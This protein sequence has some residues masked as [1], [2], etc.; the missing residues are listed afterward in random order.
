MRSI[1]LSL[2]GLA[3]VLGAAGCS[4]PGNSDKKSPPQCSDGQD[5]DGDGTVDFPDDLGCVS[6]S[7]DSEDSPQSPQCND[8]R[9]NDG[10]G[11][12]DYPADPGCFAEQADS[13]VDDCPSGPNC[14]QCADD[15]DNDGNGSIDYP[16]DPGCESASDNQ[17]FPNNPV[18]CGATMMIETLPATGVVDGVL[19]AT[20]TSMLVSPC[21]GGGGSPARAYV[22]HLTQ[23]KVVEIS[24]DDSTTTAD[25]IIDLRSKNC[26]EAAAEIA[27][28]D[29][30]SATNTRSSLLEP[31]A[32]GSYY[33]IVSGIDSATSGPF[34]LQVKL[35]NGEGTQ[36]TTVGDCGP[37]LVCRTPVGM[38]SNVC[39]R[40]VC[41]DGL[42]DDNDGKI[43]FPN[44]PGCASP[45]DT[46]EMDDCP[47]GPNCPEC[48]DGV[49]NDNDT[50][51]DYPMD[52]TCSSAADA[53]ETCPSSDGVTALTQPMT[54]GDTS[55]ATHDVAPSGS[56]CPGWTT[57]T[58]SMATAPDR[59]YRLDV[60]GLT[61]LDVTLTPGSGYDAAIALYNATCGGAALRCGDGFSV[62]T[63]HL[64][65]VGAGTYYLLVDGYYS[66]ESGT[67]T[68]A[69]SG[70]IQN[71]GSCEGALAQSGALT[72]NAGHACKGA[73]GARTCQPA[74]CGD[75]IDNDNDGKVDFPFDPGCESIA[76]DTEDNPATLPVC[77]NN[78]DDDGDGQIDFPNDYGCVSAAGTSE[79]FCM[80]E[81]DA[82]ALITS[83]VTL[84]TTI[85]KTHNQTPVCAG[86][87]GTANDVV[88]ALSLPVP[89]DTLVIDTDGTMAAT[90]GGVDTVLSVR[91]PTC[92]T[93][94][95]ACNDDIATDNRAS[96]VT[97][98]GVAPGNYSIIV[99]G[100]ASGN[101]GTPGAFK[102]NVKGTVGANALCSSPLFSGASPVL[103]CPAP[104]TCMGSGANARCQ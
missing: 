58:P 3:L 94:D 46:D 33:I 100:W 91:S 89:V 11:L 24:T 74:L 87:T 61:S 71:G 48:S 70:K 88:Y 50:K 39:S 60:P 9:D 73:A 69:V 13:E 65:T 55:T 35:Y 57:S 68:L 66:D 18:A 59:W 56:S 95:L 52:T 80:P 2:T 28:S 10:D 21:G 37:G 104:T 25:T 4:E 82:T 31:L 93:P 51:T 76:D 5:N 98:T 38:S 42:D 41:D 62:D 86:S 92:A 36:C 99:D 40:P 90:D 72:C 17:E 54:T 6:D 85:G 79:V 45:D 78:A 101:S 26:M 15:Q 34:R 8:G 27:C 47:N 103:F 83:G 75:G 19:D 30:I 20:S 7:D 96:R 102:L 53:S 44:D 67:Y 77:G 22:L 43:D 1:L 23:P 63:L 84:G 49:D 29:D 16:N 64:D 12:T 14:P 81:T 32:A 97:L